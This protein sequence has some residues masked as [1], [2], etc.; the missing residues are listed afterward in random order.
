[1]NVRNSYNRR[2]NQNA[3]TSKDRCT[4]AF[5]EDS[6]QKTLLFYSNSGTDLRQFQTMLLMYPYMVNMPS[7]VNEN[8][9][10]YYAAVAKNQSQIQQ[11]FK[12]ASEDRV[13]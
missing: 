7:T 5:A 11:S 10:H 1:M 9:Y 2:C 13:S 4:P 12:W 8:A 3:V 6:M